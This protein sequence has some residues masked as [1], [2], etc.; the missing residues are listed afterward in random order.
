MS[1]PNDSSRSSR[2]RPPFQRLRAWWTSWP[3]LV[4]GTSLLLV[5][6]MAITGMMAW[7]LWHEMRIRQPIKAKG[8]LTM[9]RSPV[10][11]QVRRQVTRVL[12]DD[13]IKL[14]SPLES[15]I[16][17]KPV[18]ADVATLAQLGTLQELNIVRGDLSS[19]GLH[20]IR[21][22][23]HLESLYLENDR[24]I[25]DGLQGLPS[26]GKLNRLK[27]IGQ[28]TPEALKPLE[29][30]NA[31]TELHL[32]AGYYEHNATESLQKR[33]TGHHMAVV[34][35]IPNLR[36]LVITSN[37]FPDIDLGNLQTARNLETL[38][39]DSVALNGD[40]LNALGRMNRL[41]HLTLEVSTARTEAL[42]HL[43][44][45]PHLKSL[46]LT[47]A[48]VRSEHL[49]N[50]HKLPRLESLS[51]VR[52]D[53]RGSLAALSR[54]PAL[55]HLTL[56]LAV[57]PSNGL[58]QLGIQPGLASIS[59]AMTDLEETPPDE[60][61]RHFPNLT[62][63]P[64]PTPKPEFDYYKWVVPQGNQPGGGFF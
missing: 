33:L 15:L 41:T 58:Q 61:Q 52:A 25:D 31:L 20:Q 32:D 60:L 43:T 3:I 23:D 44:G 45:F 55:K 4:R 11:P 18:D 48:G 29:R 12:R 46:E 16:L 27:L 38:Y 54:L 14:L 5:P 49:I 1:P 36:T 28:L 22:L 2:G 57:L 42:S 10:S 17:R 37:D 6:F 64:E 40:A 51:L 53:L 26:C 63:A 21:D 13:H 19:Q 39:V 8:E 35:R 9:G 50:L 30:C 34:A 24:I 7:R 62:Q 59:L 47:G 56:D